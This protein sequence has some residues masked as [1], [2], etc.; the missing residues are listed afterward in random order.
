VLSLISLCTKSGVLLSDLAI[1]VEPKP[2]TEK[3]SVTLI[4][5]FEAKE[6]PISGIRMNIEVFII[7]LSL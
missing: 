6:M 3:L 2:P 5:A 1:E 4:A 7:L